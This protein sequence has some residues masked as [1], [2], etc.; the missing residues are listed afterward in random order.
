M[1]LKIARRSSKIVHKE[2]LIDKIISSGTFEI[3]DAQ[4]FIRTILSFPPLDRE[5]SPVIPKLAIHS[6]PDNQVS[7]D[8]H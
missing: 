4:M 3:Y 2:F 1:L 5:S 7:L 8:K 6:A